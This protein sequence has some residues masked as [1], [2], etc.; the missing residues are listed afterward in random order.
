MS[1]G[2]GGG[3]DSQAEYSFCCSL[4]QVKTTKNGWTTDIYCEFL[5]LKSSF[6]LPFSSYH[7]SRELRAGSTSHPG[8]LQAA[9]R[10]FTPADSLRVFMLGQPWIRRSNLPQFHHALGQIGLCDTRTGAPVS[11]S[12]RTSE[13]TPFRKPSFVLRSTRNVAE[14]VSVFC[15]ESYRRPPDSKLSTL[16]QEL[17]Y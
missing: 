10:P 1:A 17:S 13:P 9:W 14:H 2:R 8:A 7:R 3:S 16:S 11:Q 12:F 4:A 5:F 15:V 6:S